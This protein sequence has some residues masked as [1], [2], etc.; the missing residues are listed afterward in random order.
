MTPIS[1]HKCCYF[2]RLKNK[3]LITLLCPSSKGSDVS[4]ALSVQFSSVAQ[5]CPTLC[6]PM[7]H[8]TPDLPVHH[9]LRKFTQTHVHRV[10]DAIQ[11][12]HPVSSPF[13]PECF[14]PSLK[15][16]PSQA[17]PARFCFL[18]PVPTSHGVTARLHPPTTLLIL[19]LAQRQRGFPFW[20]LIAGH[21]H[22]SAPHQILC[23]LRSCSPWAGRELRTPHTGLLS[24][25]P[26][27]LVKAKAGG[28]LNVSGP[29]D[30]AVAC[31]AAC[32]ISALVSFLFW[33]W[34]QLCLIIWPQDLAVSQ[35]PIALREVH[36]YYG[37]SQEG[38]E[39]RFR[40]DSVHPPCPQPSW[41]AAQ[42]YLQ[43]SPRASQF[44]D[45][46]ILT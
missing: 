13:P 29:N 17:L 12:S 2:C 15:A 35:I 38:T 40:P 21:I 41:L 39:D 37:V 42:G 22:H 6:D 28:L 4:W 5:L 1:L 24:P 14:T 36:S 44:L 27:T 18:F 11:P 20:A 26:A 30:T 3:H 43:M 34:T 33:A 9:Q 7:N 10:G 31:G 25:C 23:C 19:P 46:G 8:S 45:G 16:D 32:P